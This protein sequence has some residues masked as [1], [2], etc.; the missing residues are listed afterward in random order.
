MTIF[1]Y[2]F[3]NSF[4]FCFVIKICQSRWWLNNNSLNLH[5]K[6]TN[7][8]ILVVVVKWRY[9]AIVL[10]FVISHVNFIVNGKSESV[11]RDQVFPFLDVYCSLLLQIGELYNASFIHMFLPAISLNFGIFSTWIW[12]LPFA[13]NVT[14]KLSI[15]KLLTCIDRIVVPGK[16]LKNWFSAPFRMEWKRCTH[17]ACYLGMVLEIQDLSRCCLPQNHIL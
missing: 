9:R 12:S 16:N 3:Q 17:S 1:D 2:N 13:V 15:V 11:P 4:W 6:T 7:S 14:L 8:R 10:L 5:K